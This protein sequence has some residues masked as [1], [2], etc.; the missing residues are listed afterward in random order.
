MD[1]EDGRL[2]PQFGHVL[3]I[4]L[5]DVTGSRAQQPGHVDVPKDAPK[6]SLRHRENLKTLDAPA[7]DSE[8]WDVFVYLQDPTRKRTKTNEVNHENVPGK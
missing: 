8:T 7:L 6:K 5:I 4:S 2:G 1:E 3:G